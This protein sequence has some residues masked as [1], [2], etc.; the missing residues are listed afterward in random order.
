VT[1]D[2]LTVRV[3]RYPERDVTVIAAAGDLTMGLAADFWTVL[4][5]QLAECP[6]GLVLDLRE[7]TLVQPLA[8]TVVQ[9]ALRLHRRSL[10]DVTAVVCL[11]PSRLTIPAVRG[12][13]G[14]DF[15][16][17]PSL[18]DAVRLAGA[19]QEPPRRRTADLP[20]ANESPR[21][22]R[23][24]VDDACTEWGLGSLVESAQLVASELVANA[25]RHAH[26]P[27]RLELLYRSRILV[28]RVSD[29][30][31]ALP[32][33]PGDGPPDPDAREG[34]GLWVVSRCST[35]WGCLQRPGG[36]TVWAAI[37]AQ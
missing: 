3:R 31:P 24:V 5:Q 12:A 14:E 9:A 22:A 1:R 19:D 11:Q 26:S 37:R 13:I 18:P 33:P 15:M 6:V 17:A 35:S 16:V 28:I 36:K 32:R 8:L 23:G 34:R 21:W 27:A 29:E 10:P 20:W 4:G 7:V 25:C 30:S 2:A